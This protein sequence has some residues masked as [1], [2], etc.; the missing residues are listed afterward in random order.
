MLLV[1]AGIVI[2]LCA[3][4]YGLKV[5]LKKTNY[6]IGKNKLKRLLKRGF[7]LMDTDLI[8]SAI[9]ELSDFDG[10]H[11]SRKLDK[12]LLQIVNDFRDDEEKPTLNEKNVLNLVKEFVFDNI[13]DDDEEEEERQLD[14]IEEKLQ[15]SKEV[16]SEVEKRRKEILL[17]KNMIRQRQI[18]KASKRRSVGGLG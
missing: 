17:R 18:G 15:A 12:Y 8:K 3:G 1:E 7:D 4:A 14:E 13:F 16:L 6:K 5:L 11:N 10:K 2:G 9:K